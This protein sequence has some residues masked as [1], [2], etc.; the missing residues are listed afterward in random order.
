MAREEDD[1]LGHLRPGFQRQAEADAEARLK[2][3]GVID[4]VMRIIRMNPPPPPFVLEKLE[5]FDSKH[6]GIWRSPGQPPSRC[7][8]EALRE[9]RELYS[10]AGEEA[11][12]LHS[13]ERVAPRGAAP[14]PS[15][16]KAPPEFPNNLVGRAAR[17][18]WEWED[19]PEERRNN[20]EAMKKDLETAR[21]SCSLRTVVYARALLAEAD[22]ERWPPRKPGRAAPKPA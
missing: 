6:A 8:L 17:K 3:L 15:A 14:P 13:E 11:P 10:F 7:E 9:L 22:P 19:Y 21:V 18:L 4:L 5:A 20:T 2:E 16:P 12:P 1:P